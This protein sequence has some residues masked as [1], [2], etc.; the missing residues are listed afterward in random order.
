MVPTQT[1]ALLCSKCYLREGRVDT[2]NSYSPSGRRSSGCWSEE[3]GRQLQ[4]D[5]P[6]RATTTVTLSRPP[7]ASESETKSL[8][9]AD[10]D[11]AV[12]NAEAMVVSSTMAVSP[13]VHR[14]I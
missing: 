7:A 14:R 11:C 5:P 6:K 13:S 12:S 4:T 2:V 1:T 9:A 3:A 8:Q 10:A